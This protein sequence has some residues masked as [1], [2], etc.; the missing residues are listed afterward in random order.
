MHSSCLL[1]LLQC[2]L[3]THAEIVVSEEG[4]KPIRLATRATPSPK[5][6]TENVTSVRN[7]LALLPT[8]EIL[9]LFVITELYK[10]ILTNTR[11][12]VYRT[13]HIVSA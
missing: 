11:H 2:T 9:G 3:R 7:K 10:L 1:P 8:T 12:S 4:R 13:Q 6:C 5:S